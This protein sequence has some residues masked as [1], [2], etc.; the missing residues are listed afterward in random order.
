MINPPLHLV[1][2]MWGFILQLVIEAPFLIIFLINTISVKPFEIVP[3]L[4][5]GNDSTRGNDSKQIGKPE[6]GDADAASTR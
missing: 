2:A 5:R 3:K 6:K 4:Q 1:I